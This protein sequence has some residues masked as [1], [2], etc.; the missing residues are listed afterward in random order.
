[1][2]RSSESDKPPD[3]VEWR[4]AVEPDSSVI[5]TKFAETSHAAGDSLSNGDL[6]VDPP[7]K[8][9]ATNVV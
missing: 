4:E 2:S 5:T 7:N 3:W 6:E 8:V 9:E 1:M